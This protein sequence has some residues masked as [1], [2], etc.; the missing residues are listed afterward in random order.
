MAKRP[1]R[2]KEDDRILHKG[3]TA[4]AIRADLSLAPFDKAVV[5]LMGV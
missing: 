2:Q 3:A 1:T 4:N 5:E